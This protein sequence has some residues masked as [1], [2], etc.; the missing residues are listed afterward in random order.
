MVLRWT[1]ACI[2]LGCM[3]SLVLNT[4][5]SGTFLSFV[6]F[7][8]TL[9]SSSL[10]LILLLHLSVCMTQL[11]NYELIFIRFYVSEFPKISWHILILVK[12]VKNKVV[13]MCVLFLCISAL[14]CWT[15]LEWKML[16]MK[17][18][19]KNEKCTVHVFCMS[20]GFWDK[21]KGC[22]I[23]FAVQLTKQGGIVV[24]P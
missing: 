6:R 16:W 22:C 1:F 11:K 8:H 7:F 24:M 10:S 23:Y 12:A 3:C 20:F 13:F 4:D 9:S 15:S 21:E 19:K 14:S 17:A 2:P 5:L 18:L